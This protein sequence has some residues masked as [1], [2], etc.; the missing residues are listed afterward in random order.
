MIIA[1]LLVSVFPLAFNVQPVKAAGGKIYIRADGS[2]DPPSASILNV[3]N[4]YYTFTANICESVVVE[5]DNI[6]L[7]G[8]GYTIQGSGSGNGI[9]MAE[10]N[11]VTIEN[12]EVRGFYQGIMIYNSSTGNSVFG[13][14]AINN[15]YAGVRVDSSTN[16]NVAENVV[17]GGNEGIILSGNGGNNS[18]VRNNI[19]G[20]EFYGV[21][22]IST[23]NNLIK[24]NNI[25][26]CGWHGILVWMFSCNNVVVEN[27]VTKCKL[28]IE[29]SYSSNNNTVSNNCFSMNQIVGVAIG[30]RIPESGPD[31]GGAADNR[32]IENNVTRNNLGIESIYSKNNTIFHNNVEENNNSVAIIGSY[33]NIWDDGAIGNHWSDYNGTDANH[34]NI[35]DTP[36]VIDANNTD[37]YPL[38]TPYTSPYIIPEFPSPLTTL[39]FAMATLLVVIAYR[40]KHVQRE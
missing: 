11:N 3:G 12:V 21:N 6:V 36:Y 15:S 38:M 31:W 8:S 17:V 9:E 7:D 30:Y 1:M 29:V 37:R 28:G 4:I 27:N 10:R 2:V 39:L 18:V 33:L 25:S 20:A 13:V 22:I 35:G 19:E 23:S 26:N 16:N 24:N 5:R 40:R 32:I 14:R 34:D